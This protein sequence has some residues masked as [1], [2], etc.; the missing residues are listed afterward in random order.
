MKLTYNMIFRIL[1]KNFTMI[2]GR[3]KNYFID[4]SQRIAATFDKE[5]S[6]ITMYYSFEKNS[7]EIWNHHG[8][9]AIAFARDFNVNN[10]ICDVICIE[11]LCGAYND[12]YL[13][14]DFCLE[15]TNNSEMRYLFEKEV[16]LQKKFEAKSYQ[17]KI[18]ILEAYTGAKFSG[19]NIE[20]IQLFPDSDKY[21]LGNCGSLSSKNGIASFDICGE[22]EVENMKINQQR[23]GYDV[24]IINC[25]GQQKDTNYKD[26][27]AFYRRKN[28]WNYKE[29]Y[30]TAGSYETRDFTERRKNS[31]IDQ[32]AIHISKVFLDAVY[33]KEKQSLNAKRLQMI[34]ALNVL[35][36]DK[37][38]ARKYVETNYAF[39]TRICDLKK[40]RIKRR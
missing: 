26:V 15:T 39:N 9:V 6:T 7:Y 3:E 10:K 33:E 19:A 23:D 16:S 24:N 5:L 38:L 14:E 37:D 40:Q 17:E 27:Y 4:N 30:N 29:G 35:L 36:N 1:Q 18:A 28:D 25:K 11:G 21:A 31:T 8:K 13:E 32:E 2:A 22:I 12:F 20:G 34:Y